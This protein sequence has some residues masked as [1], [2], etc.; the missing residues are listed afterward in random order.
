MYKRQSQ[1]PSAGTLLSGQGIH[2]I[3]MT[4]SDVSGNQQTCSFNIQLLDASGPSITCAADTSVVAPCGSAIISLDPPTGVD[5]CGSNLNFTNDYGST[6][7]SSGETLVTWTATDQNGNSST[8]V[9]TVN[10]LVPEVA[11][12]GQGL[13]IMDGSIGTSKLNG[14]NFGGACVQVGAITKTYTIVN[15]GNGDLHLTGSPLVN[16]VGINSAQFAVNQPS[17][18]TLLPGEFT[19]FSITFN[20]NSLGIKFA[21]VTIS[22]DDCDEPVYDFTIKGRG[23]L[24]NSL[25]LTGGPSKSNPSLLDDLPSS[26]EKDELQDK[27]SSGEQTTMSLQIDNI[28]DSSPSAQIYPN[29]NKGQFTLSWDGD[30]DGVTQLII[31][32]SMGQIVH[33]QQITNR[34]T[35]MQ[36]RQLVPGAYQARM[37]YNEGMLTIPFIVID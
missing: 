2:T 23:R 1:S 30:I 5:A 18:A 9:Q 8:C 12:Y 19:T 15:A 37:I 33:V 35:T 34:E 24:C 3:Q 4:V 21:R 17:Q 13:S 22:T 10:V 16:V 32:N 29:P 7:F 28:M 11:L 14:T 36:I 25:Q 27:E 31:V 6:V 26:D 20:P